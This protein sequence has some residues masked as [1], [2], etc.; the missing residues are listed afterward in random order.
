[1]SGRDDGG[2]RVLI[3]GGRKYGESAAELRAFEVRMA[4]FIDRT[5]LVIHGGCSGADREAGMW[6]SR[7]KIPCMV[8]PAHF[9][10]G[11]QWGPIR[12]GW[13]LKFGKPDV[14][15]AFPGGKGTADMIRQA[16]EAGIDV[17]SMTKDPA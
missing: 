9:A 7:N 3:C 17:C 15:L 14:V 5:A 4:P 13:M 2:M 8:F 12:N 1:M 11:P 10:H 6:A 16:T